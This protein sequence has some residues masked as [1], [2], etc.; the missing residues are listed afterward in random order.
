MSRARFSGRTVLVTG[1]ASGIGRAVARRLAAE[2][3]TVVFT[4][5]DEQ[6]ARREAAAAA[7]LGG[8][9]FAHP[10]QVG[11]SASVRR[12]ADALSARGQRV[13]V[14]INN[15]AV[16]SDVPLHELTDEQWD[17]EVEVALRGPF[18]LSRA[19]LP[20]MVRAGGGCIVNIGS[21]NAEVFLG[22]DAYSA[23]KAGLASLTRTIAV[24][25][26][27]AGIRCNLV[28][29]GTVRTA[30]WAE[31]LRRDP[32]VL[33]RVRSWYPL[34][35]VGE[36]D[37]IAAAVLFLASDEASWISGIALPVDGGLLAGNGRFVADLL[38]GQAE[39]ERGSR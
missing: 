19:L 5:V 15:A 9:T 14:L 25:Y 4:D 8:A 22:C 28:V 34:G 29:P 10:V 31:R 7:D 38:A 18:L 26:G 33:D 27:P 21:V 11:D 2:Q 23:A 24:R 30:A 6:G 16:A 1:A 37:D 17:R 3:A 13:D 12:L 20:G 32:Q 39:P 35:R 36:P